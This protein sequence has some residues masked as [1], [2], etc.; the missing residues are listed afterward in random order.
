MWLE[1]E[2]YGEIVKDSEREKEREVKER[3]KELCCIDMR[4]RKR[5]IGKYLKWER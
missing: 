3:G 2:F 5:G 4:G 1:G